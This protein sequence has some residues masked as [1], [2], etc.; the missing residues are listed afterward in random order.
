MAIIRRTSKFKPMLAPHES[1]QTLPSYFRDLKFPLFVSPKL[2]GIRCLPRNDPFE[3]YISLDESVAGPPRLICKSRE[4]LDI[5]SRQVQELFSGYQGL[6]GELTEGNPTDKDVYNRTQSFVMS[7]GKFSERM[8]FHAFD[9][10][11]EEYRDAPFVER[12]QVVHTKVDEFNKIFGSDVR[13]VHHE[14]CDTLEEFLYWEDEYL[15][16]GFEGLMWKSPFGPYKWGRGT[17][18][19]GYNGKLKRFSDLELPLLGIEE[20]MLNLNEDVRSPLGLA[21]R[22]KSKEN[23]VPAGTTGK[24]LTEFKGEPIKVS[25]GAMSHEER[26]QLFKNPELRMGHLFTL[27]HFPHGQKDRLRHPRFVGWRTKGF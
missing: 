19:E 25:C 16:A 26:L 21:K 24:L 6:D 20:A 10:A 7:A 5:P 3:D 9:Y 2:D 1:P 15:E 23:L 22:S 14:L 12:L 4:F 8:T 18:L 11:G 17:W 27:R 13:V